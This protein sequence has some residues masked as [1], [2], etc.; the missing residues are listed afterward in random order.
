MEGLYNRRTDDEYAIIYDWVT[1]CKY[2]NADVKK[3]YVV[4]E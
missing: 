4:V 1:M 2:V 3:L